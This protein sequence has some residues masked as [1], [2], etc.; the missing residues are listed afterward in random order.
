MAHPVVHFEIAAEDPGRLKKFYTEL[1][2]WSIEPVPGMGEYLMV[3]TT[4]D[5]GPGIN[6][7]M[8]K[9]QAPQHANT[10]YV[11]VESVADYAE[12]AKKL[13][14]QVVV[15]KTA[16]PKMGYFAVCLD[17]DGNPIGIYEDDPTAA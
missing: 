12:K 10:N 3:K 4:G 8:M 1:F 13:G 9:K 5:G 6:G 11:Q 7:G 16:I 14:G 2:G 15:P 17:P